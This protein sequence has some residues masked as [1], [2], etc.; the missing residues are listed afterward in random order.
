[1]CAAGIS[2]TCSVGSDAEAVEGASDSLVNPRFDD[3]QNG[4]PRG[5]S[6]DGALARRGTLRVEAHGGAPRALRLSPNDR[7]TERDR[8]YAIGQIV[9]ADGLQGRTVRFSVS[10]GAGGGASA[11]ALVFAVSKSGAMVGSIL[12]TEA[13]GN[14]ALQRKEG[15]LEVSSETARFIVACAVNGTSGDAWFADLDFGI[16]GS[17]PDRST[18]TASA[19]ERPPPLASATGSGE[20]LVANGDFESVAGGL[21]A[22]WVL[23]GGLKEKGVA[24]VTS[25]G[26]AGSRALKLAPSRRNTDADRPFAL[27]QVIPAG[28]L[29]GSRVRV[30]A[31][32][33]SSEGAR[34][35]LI[36]FAASRD[37]KPLS[38]VVLTESTPA[39]ALRSHE[40]NLDIPAEAD[41]LIVGASVLGTSGSAWLDAVR[42]ETERSTSKAG[43]TDHKAGTQPSIDVDATTVLRDIPSTLYGTNIEWFRNANELWNPQS[44][45]FDPA[46]VER[47]KALQLG[48]IR[49]PG[50][51]LADYYNWRDGIGPQSKRRTTGHGSDSG[52]SRHGVGTV[53]LLQL[54]RMVGAEPMLQANIITGTPDE[55]AEWVSYCNAPRHPEREANG[56]SAPY[57]VQYWEV[58]NEQYLVDTNPETK[59]SRI[60]ARDYLQRLQR[61][62]AAMKK[63]DPSIRI[64]AI[65]GA[66]YGRYNLVSEN[67]W[68]K[69]VLQGAGSL[70]DFL[71]IH[72]AYA[73]VMIGDSSASFDQVYRGLLASPVLIEQNL[74]TVSDQIAG[75]APKDASRIKIAV[76]EW[77]PLFH[78]LPTDRWIDHAKTLGSGLFVASTL[79]AFLRSDRVT[80]ANFFKLAEHNFLG[81]IGPGA[82]PKPSYYAFE[83]F[84]RHF[85]QRLI[86]T[87]AQSPTYDFPGVGLV[88]GVKGVPYLDAVSSVST[89]GSRLY[90]LV[91]N[92]HFTTPMSTRIRLS[93]F[94][95]AA[96]GT[97]WLLT[98]PSLDAN[99]GDD[100]PSVPGIRWAHQAK[101]PSGSTFDAGR[102]GTVE[103]RRST[104]S[105]ASMDFTFTFPPISVTSLELT[106][107]R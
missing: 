29:R 23:D 76:T 91:V 63:A 20:N 19:G 80:I 3:V 82:V 81:M 44:H 77:G 62:A 13:D 27:G 45:S 9:S 78:V 71:S 61:F 106:R 43:I 38:N 2:L 90:V 32:L 8:P 65:G 72:N 85:G 55:A 79:Q 102:P 42:I 7:N 34:P 37:N 21:P 104:I 17:E 103:T 56:S 94:R 24:E 11:V 70:I 48:L 87:A 50:G 58:G 5:W 12:L 66:N 98:G 4:V 73:P 39:D 28:N 47:I 54:C 67:D 100:L 75:F 86:R 33:R 41:H 51:V 68:N 30:S 14:G 92:R 101:A 22:Q 84:T 105:N 1:M 6:L 31:A 97:V 10:V 95:P 25:D 46:S 15:R 69:T 88:A 96:D 74:K 18:R 52:S 49:F 26:V 64:G 57:K 36:V 107:A 35:V 59:R 83:M 53:E 93:G 99:N 60:S 40:A 89:D 16:E